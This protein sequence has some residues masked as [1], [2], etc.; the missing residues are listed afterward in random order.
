MIISGMEVRLGMRATNFI[1]S[2]RSSGW[3]NCSRTSGGYFTLR[4]AMMG[5]LTSSGQ[6]QQA[7]TPNFQAS[8]VKDR[9]IPS[10]PNFEG[11][12]AMPA[13]PL[14]PLAALGAAVVM[15]PAFLGALGG[16]GGRTQFKGP[17]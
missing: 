1:V 17:A 4:R 15:R 14:P 3:M 7:R 5:G 9:L 2:A 6:R 10:M 12:E 16:R 11:G 8:W 13:T